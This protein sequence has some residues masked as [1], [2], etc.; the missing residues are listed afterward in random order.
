MP[1]QEHCREKIWLAGLAAIFSRQPFLTKKQSYP[2]CCHHISW[3]WSFASMGPVT[4]RA[5]NHAGNQ[6]FQTLSKYV[7]CKMWGFKGECTRSLTVLI[8]N[9]VD[10]LPMYSI[11]WIQ[12][13]GRW[14]LVMRTIK[15]LKGVWWMPWYAQ[16][17]KDVIRCDK[18]RGAAN[19]LW[20]GDFRMGKPTSETVILTSLNFGLMASD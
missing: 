17:M 2:P 16:A 14:S 13:A 4:V 20:S 6:H 5:F 7:V 8:N 3:N 10:C 9:Q 19:K 11:S 15:C 18:R 12:K 1:V